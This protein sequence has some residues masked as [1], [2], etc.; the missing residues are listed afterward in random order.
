MTYNLLS[1]FLCGLSR[2]LPCL[3]RAGHLSLHVAS[4][5]GW[6]VDDT[7][8]A[9]RLCSFLQLLL[10]LLSQELLLQIIITPTRQNV[11]GS[12]LLLDGLCLDAHILKKLNIV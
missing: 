10:C 1:D 6:R 3:L 9:S 7:I 2:Y 4:D 11:G 5:R 12:I 8:N